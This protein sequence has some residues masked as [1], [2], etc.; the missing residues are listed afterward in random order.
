[1]RIWDVSP[2]LLCRKHLLACH[3]ELHTIHSVLLNGKKGYS[4]H[5]ETV[6]W[7]GKLAALAAKHDD[8]VA[9][10]TARGFNHSS[11]LPVVSDEPNQDVR[12]LSDGEQIEL[13]Q[14]KCG[15]CRER[16]GL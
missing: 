10:M 9:E 14:H 4:K 16:I 8:L 15:D 6:R 3:Y 1:M 12:L 7:T 11:P 2:K 5:P 13:L